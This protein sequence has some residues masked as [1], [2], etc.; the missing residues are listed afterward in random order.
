MTIVF[1]S[2]KSENYHPGYRFLKFMS[3][4]TQIP[5]SS[6]SKVWSPFVNEQLFSKTEGGALKEHRSKQSCFHGNLMQEKFMHLV[7]IP[8]GQ[9]YSEIGSALSFVDP[10]MVIKRF[11]PEEA[12]GPWALQ[13]LPVSSLVV[14]SSI[15]GKGRGTGLLEPKLAN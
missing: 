13:T 3:L 14:F 6:R 4:E 1:I 15:P 9:T 7:Y 10:W 5:L 2:G 8:P 11:P 12:F